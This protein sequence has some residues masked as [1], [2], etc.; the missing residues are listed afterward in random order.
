MLEPQDLSVESINK[1][2]HMHPI[3]M[4][5]L[6]TSPPKYVVFLGHFSKSNTKAKQLTP[7][8]NLFQ[9]M[10]SFFDVKQEQHSTAQHKICDCDS[11]TS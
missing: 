11:K 5:T 6:T 8:R 9:T 7:L 1:R 3:V 4:L 2:C 10:I